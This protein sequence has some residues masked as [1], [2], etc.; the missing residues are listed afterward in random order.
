MIK[1][2]YIA[3]IVYVDCNIL[4]IYTRLRYNRI[5]IHNA[6]EQKHSVISILAHNKRKMS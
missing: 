2:L 1:Y 6:I 3:K 4:Q 5:K